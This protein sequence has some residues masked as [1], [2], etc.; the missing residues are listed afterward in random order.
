[1]KFV[2]YTWM[3]AHLLHPVF[4]LG[5]GALLMGTSVGVSFVGFAFICGVFFSLP[6]LPV[7]WWLLKSIRKI[8]SS[9]LTKLFL[10]FGGIGASMLI[11]EWLICRLVSPDH[12]RVF[13]LVSIPGFL[14]A[15]M[16]TLILYK[17]FFNSIQITTYEDDFL[18]ENE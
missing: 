17:Q 6:G 13:L 14:S 11:G 12:Y 3:L 5:Y 4:F 2:V 1:M 8:K 15:V 7:C 18:T 16:A 10:W 9:I